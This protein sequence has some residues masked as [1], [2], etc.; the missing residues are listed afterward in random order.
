M[1]ECTSNW[2]TVCQPMTAS[3]PGV[4]VKVDIMAAGPQEVDDLLDG[5]VSFSSHGL[6]QIDLKEYFHIIKELGKGGYGK[7]LLVKDIKTGQRMAMKVLDKV[8]TSR[9]SFLLEFSMAFFLSSHPNIIGCNG[10]AFTTNDYFVF[11]LELAPAGDLL[12]LILPE[13]GIPEDAAK[14]CAVQISSALEFIAEK[15]L[16]HMDIKPE[17]VLVFDQECRCVKLTDFGLARAKGAVIRAKAGSVSYMAPEMCVMTLS[18]GLAAEATLDVWAFGVIIYCLLTGEFPWQVAISDDEGYKRFV[19][20]QTNSQVDNPP[21]TWS[22]IPTGILKMFS[23][24]LAIDR[25]KRSQTTEVLKY[26]SESWKEETPDSATKQEEENLI[27]TGSAVQPGE[28]VCESSHPETERNSDN[29]QSNASV[30]SSLS[31]MS[32]LL[33]TDTSESQCEMTPHPQKGHVPET[34][35]MYD[36]EMSFHV[37]AEVDIG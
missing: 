9:R 27:Q 11:A 7:V 17:N 37:G 32:C 14:R 24:L 34:P 6:Q 2:L 29:S 18:E 30:M 36:D 22:K 23:D 5:L 19:D 3:A 28:P 4:A 35:I 8:R 12:S 26:M 33:S 13:V 16:V 20:W 1:V 15:G 21:V 10:T 25:S 31:S